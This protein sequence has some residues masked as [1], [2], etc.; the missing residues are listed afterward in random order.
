MLYQRVEATEE[1]YRLQDIEEGE[2]VK[3][4][5]EEAD[6]LGVDTGPFAFAQLERVIPPYPVPLDGPPGT[7]P[8]CFMVIAGANPTS[9]VTLWLVP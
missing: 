4:S 6:D 2:H 9:L 5:Q 3:L 7:R 8:F 1:R